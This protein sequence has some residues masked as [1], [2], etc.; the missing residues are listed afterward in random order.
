[1]HARN[2]GPG[3]SPAS[4]IR[5]SALNFIRRATPVFDGNEKDRPKMSAVMMTLTAGQID[6]R[7]LDVLAI[8]DAAS[9]KSGKAC[10]Y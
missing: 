5:E 2:H 10:I 9:G 1:M 7:L 4:R 3:P 8:V 6:I